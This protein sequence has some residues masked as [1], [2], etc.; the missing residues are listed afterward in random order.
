MLGYGRVKGPKFGLAAPGPARHR[1]RRL[2]WLALALVAYALS[3][4]DLIPDFIPVLGWLDELIILPLAL[5]WL[6]RR[7][8]APLLARARAR[9][10]SSGAPA[11]LQGAE[12]LGRWWRRGLALQ[13]ALYLLVL[14]LIAGGLW[15]LFSSP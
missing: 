2:R 12:R 14:L 4:I 8:P 7:L 9:A 6:L 13:I 15:L 11:L 1:P 5:S 10:A 3:S